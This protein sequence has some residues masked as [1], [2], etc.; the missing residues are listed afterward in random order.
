M[1]LVLA[2]VATVLLMFQL[3]LV[4]RAVLDW[5]A[6]LAG[7]SAPTTLR[8]RLSATVRTLTEPVLAPVRRVLPPLRLGPVAL[9]TAF[10]AVFVAVLVL[11]QVVLHL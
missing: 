9:D 8:G 4:G 2:V 5:T 11:R 10:L 3:L 7:P 1:T 6:V